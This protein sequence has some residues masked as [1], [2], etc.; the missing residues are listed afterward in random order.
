V[1][2]VSRAALRQGLTAFTRESPAMRSLDDALRVLYPRQQRPSVHSMAE[3]VLLTI[4]R[5]HE[6]HTQ[7]VLGRINGSLARLLDDLDALRANRPVAGR[8][9]ALRQQDMTTIARAVEDLRTLEDHVRLLLE[10]DPSWAASLRS[11]L[12]AA[13]AGPRPPVR[14]PAAF[15]PK[16]PPRPQSTR[17]AEGN[18]RRVLRR[19]GADP[20][21]V[22]ATGRPPNAVLQAAHR[23]VVA[24]GGDVA[25]TVRGLL[26]RGGADADTMVKAVLIA[27]G[28]L[29]RGAQLPEGAEWAV[30]QR[31]VSGLEFEWST[32]PGTAIS[33]RTRPPDPTLPPRAPLPP[34]IHGEEIG[35]DDIIGGWL[36]DVKTGSTPSEAAIARATVEPFWRRDV[37]LGVDVE[38]R[39]ALA[40][41]RGISEVDL[42]RIEADTL[43]Q[44]AR[45]IEWARYNGL[46]GATWA[47]TSEELAEAFRLLAQ[48][49]P[50]RL[51][52]RIRFTTGAAP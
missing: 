7:G 28:R 31:V 15:Q 32:G 45:Q 16:A 4:L 27:E 47:C 40:P 6:Q 18:L 34:G 20:R 41:P 2:F 1:T 38:I 24:S 10:G 19:A 37:E 8:T 42:A 43:G 21:E 14:R 13:L 52:D 44:M 49:L 17:A 39:E 12:S 50:Q 29:Y 33:R 5:G 25:G 36:V 51:G 9:A 46:Y 23:L 48:R 3:L 30:R 11:D 26:A 22:V 35:I